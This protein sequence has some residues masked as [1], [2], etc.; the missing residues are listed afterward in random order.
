VQ[1]AQRQVRSAQEATERLQE[2]R[3]R[4]E[5]RTEFMAEEAIRQLVEHPGTDVS[6]RARHQRARRTAGLADPC[7]H[8]GGGFSPIRRPRLSPAPNAP[9]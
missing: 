6:V 8:G 5:L 1:Y 4:T 2:A 9:V 3:L 7:D